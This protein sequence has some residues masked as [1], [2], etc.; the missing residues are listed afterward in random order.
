MEEKG[1]TEEVTGTIETKPAT[2]DGHPASSGAKEEPVAPAAEAPSTQEI[3]K[4]VTADEFKDFERRLLEKGLDQITRDKQDT[5][6]LTQKP[7]NGD[8][9]FA[10]KIADLWFTDA[11][12][13]LRLLDERND[14][15]QKAKDT[16]KS[17]QTEFWDKFYEEN[18]ALR[19][20]KRVV[21]FI[22]GENFD[23]LKEKSLSEAKKILAEK[24]LS[25][26][27]KVAESTGGKVE[28]LTSEDPGALGASGEP[29]PKIK[30]AEKK[31]VSFLDQVR[32]LQSKKTG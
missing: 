21:N 18:P 15:K 19:Q 12:E 2:M 29:T 24:S 3:K 6:K 23:D 22:Q 8:A 28:T 10:Q 4:Y 13:A 31:V 30:Q 9:E 11:A 20:H 32:K 5:E 1:Q 16:A 7:A 17:T 25:F 27:R 26:I 14:L